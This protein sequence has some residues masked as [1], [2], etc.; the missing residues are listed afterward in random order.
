VQVKGAGK[1]LSVKGLSSWFRRKVRRASCF[2]TT[3]KL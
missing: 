3:H 1:G 2:P